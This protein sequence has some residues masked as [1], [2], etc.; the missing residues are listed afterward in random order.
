LEDALKFYVACAF[1]DFHK[2]VWTHPFRITQDIEKEAEFAV[3]LANGGDV[4]GLKTIKV[5]QLPESPVFE[6]KLQEVP[7]ETGN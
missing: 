5:F 7:I 3:K 2:P 6:G 1:S 4:R